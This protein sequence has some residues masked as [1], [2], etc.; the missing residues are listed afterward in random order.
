MATFFDNVINAVNDN[1]VTDEVVNEWLDVM[2][3]SGAER[4]QRWSALHQPDGTLVKFQV[5]AVHRAAKEADRE[6]RA[7]APSA[8]G[9]GYAATSPAA[10]PSP[11]VEFPA[12]DIPEPVYDEPLPDLAGEIKKRLGI[13]TAVRLFGKH[14]ATIRDTRTEGVKVRCPF[15][16][17]NDEHP[18][19]W[20]NTEKNTWYC[21]ACR[22][23][24][25]VI[26]FYAARRRGLRPA[27]FHHS[28]EFSEVVKE[29]GEE[30][31][32]SVVRRGSTFEIEDEGATLPSPLPD[33]PAAEQPVDDRSVEPI[34]A[35]HPESHDE[36]L[37]AAAFAPEPVVPPSPEA[38]E[39]I[40]VTVDDTLRG[41]SLDRGILG[42]PEDD[43]DDPTIPSF[44]WQKVT[45][46]PSSYHGKWMADHE[47]FM[48]WLAPEFSFF[49]ALQAIAL[50][51]GHHVTCC[52][53]RPFN[54]GIQL[55][56]VGPS[57]THKTTAISS[58]KN[59]LK[60]VTGPAWD[61]DLGTGVKMIGK[62]GSGEATIKFIRH[63]IEDL[64]PPVGIPAG[65]KREVGVTAWL[66][67][68]EFS[69]FASKAN[70]AGTTGGG[71]TLKEVFIELTDFTK[72]KDEM[73]VVWDGGSLS[74]GALSVSDSF[75]C[76]CSTIQPGKLRN[77]MSREDRHS[78]FLN[79]LIPVHGKAPKRRLTSGGRRP[80]ATPSYYGPYERLWNIVRSGPR[81]EV[82]MSMA[83]LKQF[84]FHPQMLAVYDMI[85]S[86]DDN[87]S[88]ARLP[89][90]VL[91]IAFL[92]A[93]NENPR[94]DEVPEDVMVRVIEHMVPYLIKCFGRT[95]RAI[96]A[97][98]LSDTQERIV[99]WV[100]KYYDDHSEWPNGAAFSRK[101][102]AK[103]MNAETLKP[104]LDLLYS[105][106]RLAKIAVKGARV[107]TIYLIPLP[108][109][110]WEG[111]VHGKI[112]TEETYK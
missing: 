47:E 98:D 33:A 37:D 35:A 94:L 46:D 72:R 53:D 44:E 93:V 66:N 23:G 71:S 41:I 104:A 42:D 45:N 96:S 50:A 99:R 17:H 31:G 111:F 102:P 48:P 56:L 60:D 7:G 21:G 89:L 27:D 1:L 108:G 107:Q 54:G 79:R 51:C 75:F 85:E 24:G 62:P 91:K 25:D 70:R 87:D 43:D 57:G 61:S 64:H 77:V 49:L 19:A 8:A 30:L 88:I 22:V 32:L 39:P 83:A 6:R 76:W 55:L 105:L 82:P 10:E 5:V 90:I 16:A 34:E 36:P 84:D 18:S 73:E 65:V 14:Q 38:A 26:D 68:D 4:D 103:K 100:S 29:L 59:M 92:I 40:T 58:L 11:A 80:P 106:G 52:S 81:R 28:S 3:L 63:E 74:S 112:Y 12:E 86:D 69:S 97:T 78:G 110:R 9:D 13:I 2:E 67:I 95:E 20:V 109:T 101:G 15:P